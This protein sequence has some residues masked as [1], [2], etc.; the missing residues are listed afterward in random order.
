MNTKMMVITFVYMSSQ[1]KP[2]FVTS[3]PRNIR[4][5]IWVTSSSSQAGEYFYELRFNIAFKGLGYNV[6]FEVVAIALGVI[7]SKKQKYVPYSLPNSWIISI[8]NFMVVNFTTIK[9]QM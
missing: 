9:F 8:V 6:Y 7:W 2:P 5:F 1:N 3:F 4:R